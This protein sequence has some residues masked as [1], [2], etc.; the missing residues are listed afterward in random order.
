MNANVCTNLGANI[1]IAL[2]NP[3]LVTNTIN[4]QATGQI[5]IPIRNKIN[6]TS[7]T[8]NKFYSLRLIIVQ[9]NCHNNKIFYKLK[10]CQIKCKLK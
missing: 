10:I 7:T 3:L 6:P 8:H 1:Q 5:D 2:R 9:K 4:L